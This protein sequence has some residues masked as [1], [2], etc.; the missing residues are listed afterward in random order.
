MPYPDNFRGFPPERDTS[1][2]D[3]AIAAVEAAI[4][5]IEK[6]R[7]KVN[8]QVNAIMDAI[9][10]LERVSNDLQRVAG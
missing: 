9:I 2:I 1:E 10:D 8:A 7:P 6:L 5:I 4:K 3:A